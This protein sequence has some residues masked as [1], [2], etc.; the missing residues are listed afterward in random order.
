MSL[1][2]DESGGR[3]RAYGKNGKPGAVL[4]VNDRGGRVGVIGKGEVGASMGINEHGN[5]VVATYDKDG[6]QR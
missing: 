6:N 5:G 1:D 3:V 4:T 2:T